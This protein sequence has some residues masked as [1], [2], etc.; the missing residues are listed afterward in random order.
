MKTKELMETIS[1]VSSEAINSLEIDESNK[2]NRLNNMIDE[3][4]LENNNISD[5]INKIQNILGNV[6]YL[7]NETITHKNEI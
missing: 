5:M 7:N 3:T 4:I 1:K 2:L 6:E